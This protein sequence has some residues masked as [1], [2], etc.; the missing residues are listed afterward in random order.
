MSDAAPLP[1]VNVAP[2][3]DDTRN[4]REVIDHDRDGGLVHDSIEEG[5]DGRAVVSHREGEVA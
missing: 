4:S 1:N 5:E 3:P 2:S